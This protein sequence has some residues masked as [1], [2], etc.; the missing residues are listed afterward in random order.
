MPTAT[1]VN[2]RN[3]PPLARF[4]T[5]WFL[6]LMIG[7][8]AFVAFILSHY[9]SRIIT[10]NISAWNDKSIITGYVPG[11]FIGNLMLGVHVMLA[12]VMT[13]G[14]LAQ[15]IPKLRQKYPAVHR[16][17]GRV[18]LLLAV[19]LALGGLWMTWVR[20]SHLSII[21]GLSVSLNGVLIL[22]FSALALRHAVARRIAL[23]RKWALRTFM[24][25]SGVWFFRVGL[26]GWILVNQAPRGM[27][28]TL[29]GP[30]DI[31]LSLGSYLV[32]L[33]GLELYFAAQRSAS[34]AVQRCAV[35]VVSVMSLFMALGIVGAI[36]LMWF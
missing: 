11:D 24:V 8:I 1:S 13:L 21:S 31:A 2:D 3:R 20:G 12:A 23:H 22:I 6:L 4:G 14:G 19:C 10:G 28:S 34:K 17:N 25:A 15:L 29:S 27:N 26:M 5:A 30:A 9:G 7:Q 33:A 16:W 36:T 35:I 32:P 18:F